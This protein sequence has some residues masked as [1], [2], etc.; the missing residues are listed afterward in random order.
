[1]S[2]RPDPAPLGFFPVIAVLTA[3]PCLAQSAG[4][5]EALEAE[6]VKLR[7][8]LEAA[9]AELAEARAAEAAALEASNTLR[10]KSERDASKVS[11]G[12]IS[13]G[14]AVR[15]NYVYGDYETNDSGPSRG[16]HGG[17]V[18][19]D[20][21]RINADLEHGN[22]I[23]RFEYRWS[24]ADAGKNYT[25]MHSAWLGYRFDDSSHME[26]GLNRVPFGAG[27][28]GV[29]QSW[30]FD[31]HYYVGLADDSDMGMKYSHKG[32]AWSWDAAYYWRN[33][34]N[35]SGRSEDST[36]YG[37][38]AVR[39][40]ETVSEYGNVSFDQQRSGYR[41]KDQFNARFIRHFKGDDW[42]SDIGSSLQYGSLDGSRLDDGDHWAVSAHAI[43]RWD[44]LTLGVQ[45][46]RYG[47][48]I[49]GNNPW[50]TD[51]LIPLGAYDFAWPVA[52][53]AWVPALSLSYRLETPDIAWL[54][55]ALPYLEWSGILKD[56][57]DFNDSELFV[58]GAAW[59]RGGWYIYSDLAYSNGNY[60][61]GNKGD[62]Y[63]RIDGVN[64]FGVNGNDEWHYR[65]NLN[66]GYYY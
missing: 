63:S 15:V 13:F 2:L 16:G 65:L 30:F 62:D 3:T 37:Y 25:F 43:N 20:T 40:R 31:Q 17:N 8:A 24:A 34:P 45:V 59:A 19:L 56:E 60:F 32:D 29:S 64:D 50:G 7:S 61:V 6:V 48:D 10:E 35:F 58:M 9:E 57:S 42:S 27:P 28:Y 55:Y 22:L 26:V 5:V 44:N 52:S 51:K 21:F 11:L 39:W 54:D 18:E 1:M 4:P 23:G 12:P 49:D 36:R 46:S 33:E 53:D 47:F 14:G 38:D 41:E 66:F